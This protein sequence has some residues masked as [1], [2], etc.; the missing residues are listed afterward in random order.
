M[1]YLILADMALLLHAFFVF[2]VLFG[3]LAA[4]HWRRLAWLHIPAAPWGAVI[5]LSGWICPLT[6][7]EN[8]LRRRGGGTGYSLSFIEHYLDPL[9]YPLGLTRYTQLVFGISALLI[10]LAIYARFWSDHHN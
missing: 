8:H 4:L 9:L 3:G 2:F 10:N 6:Y 1:R 7:L 5:E